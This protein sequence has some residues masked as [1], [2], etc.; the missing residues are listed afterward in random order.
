MSDSNALIADLVCTRISHDLIGNIGAVANAVELL[1]EGDMDFMDDIRSILKTS[2]SVLNAR[3]KFFRMAFGLDNANTADLRT[4]A[5]VCENYLQSLGSP[6]T[7][8]NLSFG[9][10]NP[11]YAKAVMLGIMIVA[12]T[13]IRGGKINVLAHEGKVVVMPDK[14]ARFSEDKAAKI[15][16]LVQDGKLENNAQFAPLFYL[17]SL[18]RRQGIKMYVVNAGF[19]GLMFE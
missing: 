6:D 14:N 9:L 10:D 12:D 16:E 17:L 11:R 1:E 7:P 8:I 18:L 13:L 2:S 3:L 4:V 15:R 19:P 5:T